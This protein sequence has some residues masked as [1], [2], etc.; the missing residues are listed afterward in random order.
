MNM[1]KIKANEFW[2]SCFQTLIIKCNYYS[3][4]LTHNLTIVISLVE[5]R[6]LYVVI[7]PG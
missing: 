5:T 3:N 7:I 1:I 2:S 4:L 6:L